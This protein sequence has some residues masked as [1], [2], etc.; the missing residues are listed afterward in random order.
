MRVEGFRVNFLGLKGLGF[1]VNLKFPR[2]AARRQA[3][4]GLQLS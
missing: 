4:R 2:M 3:K 1:R